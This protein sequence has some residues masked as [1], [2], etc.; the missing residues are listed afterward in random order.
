MRAPW[1]RFFFERWRDG[2]K[3]FK[4]RI[5]HVLILIFSFVI[6]KGI[7]RGCTAL[8]RPIF[9]SDLPSNHPS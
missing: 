6:S 2:V 3:K 9:I 5:Q 7:I 4:V 8:N 1:R